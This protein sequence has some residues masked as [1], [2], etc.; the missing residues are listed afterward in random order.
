VLS[1]LL[2]KSVL[3]SVIATSSNSGGESRSLWQSCLDFE[4]SLF[5]DMSV[6]VMVLIAALGV[7]VFRTYL[8]GCAVSDLRRELSTLHDLL[9]GE[10]MPNKL[11]QN[12]ELMRRAEVDVVAVLEAVQRNVA[13]NSEGLKRCEARLWHTQKDI[14]SQLSYHSRKFAAE[15]EIT[16]DIRHR[17]TSQADSIEQLREQLQQLSCECREAIEKQTCSRH[18]LEEIAGKLDHHRKA[19]REEAAVRDQLCRRLVDSVEELRG[20]LDRSAEEFQILR[21]VVNRN[22]REWMEEERATAEQVERNLREI[23]DTLAMLRSDHEDLQG[24]LKL[25]KQEV[26]VDL[27]LQQEQVDE[28]RRRHDHQ[29]ST[30]AQSPTGT[31]ATTPKS[32]FT[33]VNSAALPPDM[34]GLQA[35]FSTTYEALALRMSQLSKDCELHSRTVQELENQGALAVHTASLA[36]QPEPGETVLPTAWPW[37]AMQQRGQ[38]HRGFGGSHPRPLSDS[39]GSGPGARL[40]RSNGSSGQKT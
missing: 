8:Q 1:V 34:A 22:R 4:E 21:D 25:H 10:D 15:E 16:R 6:T 24:T 31:Q 33:S 36:Q 12:L 14:Q 2:Q 9:Q 18:A 37:E 32:A 11:Q 40:P 19:T 20:R 17:L 39:P 38:L 5:E 28:L 27:K 30:T 7:V 35:K 26:S 23:S 13:A 3:T 29:A